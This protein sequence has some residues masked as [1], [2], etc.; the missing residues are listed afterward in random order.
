MGKFSG[1]NILFQKLWAIKEETKTNYIRKL[2]N[3]T[4]VKFG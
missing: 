2:S 1:K 4:L 3:Y